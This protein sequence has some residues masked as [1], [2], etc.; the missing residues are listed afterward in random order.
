M[1]DYVTKVESNGLALQVYKVSCNNY[2]RIVHIE[3]GSN[4]FSWSNRPYRGSLRVLYAR[5][6]ELAIYSLPSNVTGI[7]TLAELDGDVYAMV[8][9]LSR[10]DYDRGFIALI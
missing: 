10:F 5:F 7:Q 8:M 6:K 2:V 1:T 9:S 3:S 4:L